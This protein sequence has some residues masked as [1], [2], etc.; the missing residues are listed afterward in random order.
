MSNSDLL[1]DVWEES[2]TKLI[3]YSENI[4]EPKSFMSPNLFLSQ[5]SNQ[6]KEM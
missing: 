4:L 5:H 1:K 3:Q 2:V 6:L